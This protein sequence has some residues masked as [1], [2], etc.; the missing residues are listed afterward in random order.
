MMFLYGIL[1]TIVFILGMPFVLAVRKCIGKP[2]AGLKEK[3]GVII[4]PFNNQ[5]DIILRHGVYVG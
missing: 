5:D 2:N 4:R 1:S 3:F